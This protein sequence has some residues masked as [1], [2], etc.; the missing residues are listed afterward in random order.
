MK[1][2]TMLAVA[3][4]LSAPLLTQSAALAAADSNEPAATESTKAPVVRH[5]S[6]KHHGKHAAKHQAKHYGRNVHHP[7]KS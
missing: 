1:L 6:V 5:K 2:T 3:A 4:L 7:V